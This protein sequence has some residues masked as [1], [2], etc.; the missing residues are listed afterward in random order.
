A[1]FKL[2]AELGTEA[3]RRRRSPFGDRQIAGELDDTRPIVPQARKRVLLQRGARHRCRDEGIAVAIAADPRAELEEGWNVE[4]CTGI[5]LRKRTLKSAKHLRRHL[6]QR[7]VEE[8]QAP[9]HLLLRRRLLQM[10]LAGHPYELNLVAKLIDER[11]ALPLG[12]AGVLQ[13]AQQEVGLAVLFQHR[14]AL[15]FGRVRG[16][17]RA[18]AQIGDEP[19]DFV[20]ANPA[21]CSLGQNLAK[22]AAQTLAA[23]LTLD[24]ASAAHCGVLLGDGEKLEPDALSLK[25]SRHKLRCDVGD[26]GAALE[27]RLDLGLMLAGNVEQESE[28]KPRSFA[29]RGARDQR[30]QGGGIAR[31]AELCDIILHDGPA[32]PGGREASPNAMWRRALNLEDSVG[33][34][35][36][37][38]Q[39]LCHRRSELAWV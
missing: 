10:Q 35:P 17:H 32:L 38:G 29:R 5:R 3:V 2:A 16:D 26:G 18:D 24:L 39:H 37:A 31:P 22:R 21:P 25:R 27:Q 33:P 13:L 11:S 15:R 28:Q 7:L 23:T 9:L 12:P 14:N 8:M 6:E 19:L 4:A 36:A 1:C 30:L 20:C 34:R